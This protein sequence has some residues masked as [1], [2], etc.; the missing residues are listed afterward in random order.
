VDRALVSRALPHDFRKTVVTLMDEAGLSVQSAANQLGYLKPRC[1]H[2]WTGRN[3]ARP[4][5]PRCSKIFSHPELLT[6][7]TSQEPHPE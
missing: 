5:R 4:G 7:L 3:G 2:I 6:Q 1:L